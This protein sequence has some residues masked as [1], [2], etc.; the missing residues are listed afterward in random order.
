MLLLYK[1]FVEGYH[2]IDVGLEL[3]FIASVLDVHRFDVSEFVELGFCVLEF[4]GWGHFGH[5]GVGL[6]EHGLV[7]HVQVFDEGGRSVG[8]LPQRFLVLLQLLVQP[9]LAVGVVTQP[10]L[11]QPIQLLFTRIGHLG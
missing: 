5:G 4:V 10:G 9:A 1:V 6:I 8:L 7:L 3:M 2:F 11:V